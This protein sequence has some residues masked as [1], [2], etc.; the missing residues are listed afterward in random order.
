M[1]NLHAL[2]ADNPLWVITERPATEAQWVI[3]D[4]INFWLINPDWVPSHI[5]PTPV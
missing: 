3:W 5:V 2:F 1:G 4:L